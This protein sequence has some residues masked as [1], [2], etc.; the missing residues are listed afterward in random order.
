MNELPKLIET[1]EVLHRAT[2]DMGPRVTRIEVYEYLGQRN[3][4]K[5][6]HDANGRLVWVD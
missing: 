4:V 3:E 2:F 1:R 6:W 5:F